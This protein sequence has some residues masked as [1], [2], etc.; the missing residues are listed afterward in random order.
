MHIDT[1]FDTITVKFDPGEKYDNKA[2][3]WEP[4]NDEVGQT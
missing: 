4:D 3:D 2:H 1:L